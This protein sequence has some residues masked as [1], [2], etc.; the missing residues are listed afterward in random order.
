[1]GNQVAA[2]KTST[3]IRTVK[4]E[5]E[6]QDNRVE[7]RQHKVIDNPG[8]ELRD[9]ERATTTTTTTTT[10]NTRALKKDKTSS[11]GQRRQRR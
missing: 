3:Y 5:P 8:S 4:T 9:E 10:T 1:M 6:K 7:D 11:W 2:V